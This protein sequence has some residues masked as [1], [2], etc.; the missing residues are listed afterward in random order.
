M[1]LIFLGT[2]GG[3]FATIYQP[4]STGGIYL[5][6]SANV[7]VDPGPSAL[8]RMAQYHIDP[9]KTDA[10][11]ISHCHPDHYSD[12][13][14]LIEGMTEG[15]TKKRGMLVG[16]E[17][18]INGN[19]G[20]GPAI[21]SYH[22]SA[23]KEVRVAKP[24]DEFQL[25]SLKVTATF[26]KHTDPTTVGFK[27]ATEFGTLSYISDTDITQRMIDAH[28]GSRLLIIATTRPL[29]SK[30]PFH[31]STEDAAMVVSQIKPEMAILTHFG[32][33]TIKEDPRLQADWVTKKSGVQTIAAEDGMKVQFAKDISLQ[34]PGQKKDKKS[35]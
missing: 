6:A 22:Q 35:N 16:S 25:N 3:R 33:K 21:S 29:Y 9:S 4:R 28:K 8:W 2:A 32:L 11:L 15:T 7:H 12:A 27:F 5:R 30:I 31:L 18:V 24:G 20:I 14:V 10:I 23:V 1:N 13:E 34:D 19:D 17:S 26:A